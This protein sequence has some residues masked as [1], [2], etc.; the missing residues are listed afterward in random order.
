[1]NF[2]LGLVLLAMASA[3]PLK[4]AK[5][6]SLTPFSCCDGQF[7]TTNA[8]GQTVWQNVGGSAYLD[9]I[10]PASFAFTSGAPVYVQVVYFDDGDGRIDLEYDSVSGCAYAKSLLHTRTSRMNTKRFA[11]ACYVLQTPAFLKQQGTGADFRL[12][13][14]ASPPMSV[15]SCTIQNFA[16]TNSQFQP[17]L[18]RPWL[19]PYSGQT[20]T[21]V[22]RS[23]LC[24]KA[25]AG[26]QGWFRAPNDLA[27]EGWMHWVRN[28]SMAATNFSIDLWPDMLT[29]ATSRWSLSGACPFRIA[30]S[31]RALPT[32][33][34]ISSRTIP[35]MAATM[36]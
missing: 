25:M 33:S 12:G 14:G 1:L 16:F 9:F 36:S 10:V 13:L 24:N 32:R 35:F 5:T 27:D 34:L 4:A 21:D 22:D 6:L 31:R 18:A 26:Y 20:R 23:T 17:V 19:K 28:S 7:V 30:A 3:T 29:K 8:G 2:T 15:H 11:T